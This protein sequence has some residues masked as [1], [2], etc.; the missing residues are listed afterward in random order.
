MIVANPGTDF[1]PI[2]TTAPA[3]PD[4]S[5]ASTMRPVCLGPF[6]AASVA[7]SVGAS[8]PP[9]SPPGSLGEVSSLLLHE[10]PELTTNDSTTSAEEDAAIATESSRTRM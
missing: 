6:N 3:T 5:T 1:P 8:L 10:T 7:A 4:F 2:V 9:A